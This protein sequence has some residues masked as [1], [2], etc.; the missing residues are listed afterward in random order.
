MPRT[1]HTAEENV[2]DVMAQTGPPKARSFGATSFK[3]TWNQP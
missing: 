1:Q 3:V 2:S